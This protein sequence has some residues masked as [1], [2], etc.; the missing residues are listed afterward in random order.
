MV[1]FFAIKRNYF[2]KFERRAD[3]LREGTAVIIRLIES[4]DVLYI[5]VRSVL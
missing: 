3:G 4:E 5:R 1:S 2:L